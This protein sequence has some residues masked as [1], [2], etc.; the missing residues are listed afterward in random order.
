MTV[1]VGDRIILAD[2]LRLGICNAP[3]SSTDDL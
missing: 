1:V 3:T 2:D